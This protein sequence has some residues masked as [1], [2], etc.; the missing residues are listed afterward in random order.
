MTTTHFVSSGNGGS[1]RCPSQPSGPA[2]TRSIVKARARAFETLYSVVNR[3]SQSN[4]IFNEGRRCATHPA[5]KASNPAEVHEGPKGPQGE[6]FTLS[7][8]HMY[9]MLPNAV[10]I[11]RFKIPRG[12]VGRVRRGRRESRGHPCRVGPPPPQRSPPRGNGSRLGVAPP[13]VCRAI[14]MGVSM[15]V[16]AGSSATTP[17]V[18]RD[19]CGCGYWCGC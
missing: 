4:F 10:Q 6:A 9:L 14:R 3:Q 13:Q 15:G 5:E 16:G 17:Q 1:G 7:R 12:K 18:A 19:G 11:F 8:R 2:T